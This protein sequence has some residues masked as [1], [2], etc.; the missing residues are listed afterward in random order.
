M[1]GDTDRQ[2]RV[3]YPVNGRSEYF[4]TLCSVGT[5]LTNRRVVDRPTGSVNTVRDREYYSTSS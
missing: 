4:S 3:Q 1:D 5:D 2:N